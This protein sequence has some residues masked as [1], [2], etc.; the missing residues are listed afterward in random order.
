MA[1]FCETADGADRNAYI[2]NNIFYEGGHKR[3]YDDQTSQIQFRAGYIIHGVKYYTDICPNIE[4]YYPES[5]FYLFT[6]GFT[7]KQVTIS[8]NGY[9]DTLNYNLNG[10][11]IEIYENN[12]GY[13]NFHSNWEISEV[14]NYNFEVI[15]DDFYPGNNPNDTSWFSCY[16]GEVFMN[17]IP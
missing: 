3:R 15:Y 12:Y 5:L 8:E 14:N 4:T 10:N 9:I 7:N 11:K 2:G 13:N 17:K 6:G 16:Q 1:I